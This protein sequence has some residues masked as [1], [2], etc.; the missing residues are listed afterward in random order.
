MKTNLALHNRIKAQPAEAPQIML[1]AGEASG[2]EHSARVVSQI[3]AQCP[4]AQI[5]G[6]GGEKLRQTG[7]ELVVDAQES[8][9]VMGLTEVLGSLGRIY[10]AYRRLVHEA[11]NRRPGLAILVD[12][13]DFN[14]LLARKLYKLGIPVLYFISPQL[15]AWRRGRVNKIKKYVTKVV[16][17][18]PFEESFYHRHGVDAEYLGHPFLDRQ[19]LAESRTEWCLRHGL[20]PVRPIV[21]LLPGSRKAEVERLLPVMAQAGAAL[22]RARRG[23]Q[24][25]LPVA[26]TLERGWVG[27]LLENT[28]SVH[29]V[30]G[31]SRECLSFSDAAVVASG[32]A[33]VEAALARVPFVVVYK[34]S[35]LTYLAGRILVRGIKFFAMVNLIAG[36]E[37]VAEL[38]QR[39][40]S[41]ER[42]VLEV[43]RILGDPQLKR[44]IA[45]DLEEVREKLKVKNG[46]LQSTA[47][48]VAAISLELAVR[49][50]FQARSAT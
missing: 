43:E 38:L 29:L 21:A 1:V 2:D 37:V 25:V 44:K 4:G 49:R 45:A 24:L 12:F 34:L 17:I 26:H 41:A 13:P 9:A 16:P 14:L 31:E 42:I 30:G 22:Q 3:I 23:L 36:R 18:F 8:A 15:W 28:S 35:L 46:E 5:F 10:G 48:R 40:A 7:M 27:S 6:M 39:E 47:G 33:T 50:E 11:Q 19:P 32:T 20:D